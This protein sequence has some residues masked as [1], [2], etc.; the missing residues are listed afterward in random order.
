MF[1]CDPSIEQLKP[2]GPIVMEESRAD[3]A[4]MHANITSQPHKEYIDA[5]LTKHQRLNVLINNVGKSEPRD[6]ASIGEEVWDK[7]M[8]VN[9]TSRFALSHLVPPIIAGQRQAVTLSIS[10]LYL[11]SV[12]LQ[13]PSCIFNS[14][15]HSALFHSIDSCYTCGYGGCG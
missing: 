14:Q 7:Q 15:S 10:T 12:H 3:I 4:L 13:T 2:R 8:G 9:V 6:P 1:G 5:C 11:A